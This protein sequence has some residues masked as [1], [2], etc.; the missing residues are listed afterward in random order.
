MSDP[1]FDD[2]RDEYEDE[3]NSNP[4]YLNVSFKDVE[5]AF[6]IAYLEATSL[7]TM[8]EDGPIEDATLK[9]HAQWLVTVREIRRVLSD[10][11]QK[12]QDATAERMDAPTVVVTG[13]GVLSRHGRKNRKKWDTDA[14][15]SAVLDS[16]LV[17]SE[18]GEVAD[19]S[20]LD[21]VLMVWNLGAPR[22]MALRARSIDPDEFC[23]VEALPGWSVEVRG[24]E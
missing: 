12:I 18:T 6:G 7:S 4:A 2:Q 11:E 20:P 19:E 3:T 13:L 9:Q 10:V 5:T 21:R 23:E 14:L 17:D 22:L 1:S 15:K 16:R 8:L 24:P